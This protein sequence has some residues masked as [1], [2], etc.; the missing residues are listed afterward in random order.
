MPPARIWQAD[1][2]STSRLPAWK[3]LAHIKEPRFPFDYQWVRIAIPAGLIDRP[4]RL[5]DSDDEDVRRQL[6]SDWIR[7]GRRPVIKAPSV[8]IPTENNFLINPSI[9]HFEICHS[10]SRSLSVLTRDC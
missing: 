4:F 5:P 7:A 8:I 6:G 3:T 10:P 9:R 2:S 1:A